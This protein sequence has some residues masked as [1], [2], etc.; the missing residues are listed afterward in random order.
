MKYAINYFNEICIIELKGKIDFL[1]SQFLDKI[2]E[3]R[4]IKD[5]YKMVID[6]KDVDYIGSNGFSVLI[7]HLISCR[8]NGGDLRLCNVRSEISEVI[9]K[10]KLDEVF[11]IGTGIESVIEDF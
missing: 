3:N 6:L 1:A 8:D 9:S 2:L 11:E 7:N 10:I 5:N 4:I